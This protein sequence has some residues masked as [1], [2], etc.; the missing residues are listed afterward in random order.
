MESRTD[1]VVKEMQVDLR[2]MTCRLSSHEVILVTNGGGLSEG[3]LLIA[4]KYLMEYMAPGRDRNREDRRTETE[5][6][7][8]TSACWTVFR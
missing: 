2:P 1:G 4:L 3:G 8:G 6:T 7:G 5:D